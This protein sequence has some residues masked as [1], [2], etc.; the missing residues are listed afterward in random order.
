MF[1]MFLFFGL[2]RYI[3]YSSLMDFIIIIATGDIFGNK[4]H[5]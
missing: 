1:E 4:L 3:P 2:A 5:F